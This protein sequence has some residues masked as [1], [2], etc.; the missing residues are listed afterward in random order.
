MSRVENCL[1][2]R[3]ALNM[4][5]VPALFQQGLQQLAQGDLCVDFSETEN[6]DSAAVSMMLG[7]MRAAQAQQRSLSFRAM[8]P[9]VLSLATLYG[10]ADLIP[11][12]V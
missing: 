8:P 5:S 4:T 11:T 6:V 1:I 2:I 9:A 10:V 7:W 12:T 3:G